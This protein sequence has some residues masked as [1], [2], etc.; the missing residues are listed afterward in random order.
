VVIAT[1]DDVDLYGTGD[2][3]QEA[4]S[5]L[6]AAIVEYYEGLKENE[7]CLGDL[8]AQ[9]YAFLKQMIIEVQ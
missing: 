2:D 6:C 1:Y 4:I 8:P 5:D 3:V 9:E 7:G